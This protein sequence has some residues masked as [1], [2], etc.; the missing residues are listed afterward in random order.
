MRT[1]K[2]HSLRTTH[3]G[4]ARPARWLRLGLSALSLTAALTAVSLAAERDGFQVPDRIEV[5][6]HV[7][8]LNGLATRTATVFRVHIYVAALYLESPSAD[9]E[10]ILASPQLKVI[11]QRHDYDISER[12]VKRG[13][14]YAF[15][16]NCP[17]RTCGAFANERA[18]FD[19]LLQSVAKGDVY[20]YVFYPDRTEISLAGKPLGTVPGGEFSRLLLST[21]IGAVPPTPDVKRELLAAGENASN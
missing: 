17:D 12:D 16:Q 21:W 20:E 18:A 5:G 3:R 2:R 4:L 11:K 9:E 6:E 19:A 15:E 13:W 10:Q 1:S 7:L 8:Q 14:D